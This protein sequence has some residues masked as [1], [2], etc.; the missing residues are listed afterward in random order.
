MPLFF[1]CAQGILKDNTLVY[2]KCT[3][4]ALVYSEFPKHFLKGFWLYILAHSIKAH[5]ESIQSML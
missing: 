2:W 5:L 4:S 3:Q 1:Q